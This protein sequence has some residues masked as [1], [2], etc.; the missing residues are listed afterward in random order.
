LFDSNKEKLFGL[1]DFH[2]VSDLVEPWGRQTIKWGSAFK[3][4]LYFQVEQNRQMEGPNITEGPSY[5][6]QP[7]EGGFRVPIRGSVAYT[8]EKSSKI[9]FKIACFLLSAN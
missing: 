9:N 4:Q 1:T 7:R 2:N 8:P 6:P 3:G 5:W